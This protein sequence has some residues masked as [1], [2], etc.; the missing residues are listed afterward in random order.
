MYERRT[1]KMMMWIEGEGT[2][3]FGSVILYFTD[4]KQII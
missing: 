1:R 4:S 3:E 2:D